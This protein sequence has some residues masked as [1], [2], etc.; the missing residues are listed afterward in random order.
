MHC[1]VKL[2]RDSNTKTEF[3]HLKGSEKSLKIFNWNDCHKVFF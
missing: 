3:D 1:K 2:L